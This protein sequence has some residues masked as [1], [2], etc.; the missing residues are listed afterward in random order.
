MKF[1]ILKDGDGI[2]QAATHPC[3]LDGTYQ[4]LKQ[5]QIEDYGFS[6]LSKEEVDITKM[7]ANQLRLLVIDLICSNPIIGLDYHFD[8]PDVSQYTFPADNGFRVDQRLRDLNV[9]P[10]E[11]ILDK[12]V[13]PSESRCIGIDI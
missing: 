12:I 2:L 3:Y 7:S 6:S 9:M 1:T 8:N 11:S 5:K 10:E 13:Q 4:V